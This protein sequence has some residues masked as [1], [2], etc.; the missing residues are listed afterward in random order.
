MLTKGEPTFFG[1]R[2]AV[3][4]ELNERL[5]IMSNQLDLAD[6]LIA[7]R[8]EDDEATHDVY[9][10]SLSAV[11]KE[12]EAEIDSANSDGYEDGNSDGRKEAEEAFEDR[13]ETAITEARTQAYKEGY[14]AGYFAHAEES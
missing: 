2:T 6:T 12:V 10:L 9:I 4:A 5:T 3:I 7:I 11:E 13:M 14:E 8:L 1:I